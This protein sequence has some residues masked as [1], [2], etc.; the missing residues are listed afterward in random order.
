M[1]GLNRNCIYKLTLTSILSHQGRGR[2]TKY[3]LFLDLVNM[4]ILDINNL[5]V[6][7][8]RNASV[9]KALR[10]VTLSV[11]QG[12]TLAVVG[13]SGCGKS[14]LA[15]SIL[16]LIFPAQ[17][18]IVS[19]KII[20]EG[21]D[22]LG[23]DKEDLQNLRGKDISVVFQDPFSSLNPVLT[24]REQLTETV[25]A[26]DGQIS[27]KELGTRAAEAL[28]ETIFTDPERILSS[29]PHQLSG[30]QR[31][32]IMLAMAIINRPKILIADEP[33]TSLDVTIQKEIM[34]LIASLQKNLALTV[35][36]ITHNLMLAKQRSS[37]IAVMY[38]GEI[39]ELNS[40]ESIFSKPLHP[41]TQGLLSSVPKLL[42][43][44][45][46]SALAGQPPELSEILPGCSFA[47][48]CR[49]VMEKCRS[50]K[51]AEYASGDSKVRCFLYE[52]EGK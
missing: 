18:K 23:L 20:F 38:A 44:T 35:I 49:N 30:G 1:R 4:N 42:S 21:K 2:A 40:S 37:R 43:K 19:G 10:D 27:D 16:G 45:P 17:G 29:Y 33:T 46:P 48:R 6:E 15:M 34:D 47:P 13:E 24:I 25:A 11:T 26:H 12:E 22:I 28:K 3:I 8:Y 7:Y 36:L 41:Y 31:Q 9:V 5:S 51:P 50:T 52:G 14:T 32:R 39:V